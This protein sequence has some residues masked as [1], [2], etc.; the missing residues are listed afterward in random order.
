MKTFRT[1]GASR[2]A[3]GLLIGGCML[4][5]W[6]VLATLVDSPAWLL[7]AVVFLACVAGF[8]VGGT[9]ANGGKVPPLAV[10]AGAWSAALTGLVAASVFALAAR[11]IPNPYLVLRAMLGGAL[12]VLP[13]M[14]YG[15][16]AAGVAAVV[17][18]AA[19]SIKRVDESPELSLR[20]PVAWALRVVIALLVALGALLPLTPKP[21][22][23]IVSAKPQAVAPVAPKPPPPPPFTYKVPT[24]MA[25]AQASQWRIASSWVLRGLD[26]RVVALSKDGRWFA[27]AAADGR[28]VKIFDLHAPESFRQVYVPHAVDR[29]SFNPA[30]DRL[31]LTSGGPSAEL[32][33][34][35]VEAS[36]FTS[37]PKPKGGLMP[38][39]SVLWWKDKE[40]LIAARGERSILNLDDLEIDAAEDV[41]SW[42]E[43]SQEIRD[44]V[45]RDIDGG[46]R[47]T[48]RWAWKAKDYL[49]STELPARGGGNIL[50]VN[51]KTVV[52]MAHPDNDTCTLFG[53]LPT[54]SVNRI[55]SSGDGSKVLM[56]TGDVANICYFEIGEAPPLAWSVDMPCA[57]AD[58][59][60][61]SAV[62]KALKSG[63]LAALIYAPMTNPL[64][65]AVVG[66]Q[67]NVVKAQVRFQEWKER[68]ARVYISRSFAPV[69]TGDVVGDACSWSEERPELLSLRKPHAWWAILH[70]PEAGSDDVG[71]IPTLAARMKQAED[72]HK[73]EEAER[74]ARVAHDEEVAA[75]QRKL[76]ALKQAEAAPPAAMPVQVPQP[77]D[78]R[79]ER[80]RAFVKAHHQKS[81][82]GDVAGMVNDYAVRVDYFDKG[83]VDPNWIF[84]DEMRYHSSHTVIE[85]TV[86][87]PIRMTKL[88]NGYTASYVLKTRTREN[89][90]QRFAEMTFDVSLI[91]VEPFGSLQISRQRTTRKP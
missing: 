62:E 80:V 5:A 18:A 22:P 12:S 74:K 34:I 83:L 50:T 49:E 75:E 38:F 78:P 7:G 60:D 67:R 39:G 47:D 87:D 40:I 20:L 44:N 23:V 57:P 28:S 21:P 14:F 59:P 64:N 55:L 19:P 41:P 37:L 25:S 61:G 58:C 70:E 88:N 71:K 48:I 8:I 69:A 65:K 35:D 27:S 53:G 85:E 84:Q 43:T 56:L 63:S 89:A 77:A 86:V 54:S 26:S 76:L 16:F 51:R 11:S 73:G 4:F 6:P 81:V 3:V 10:R 36:R 42:K 45:V 91:L 82:N 46:F 79:F 29:L 24:E 2:E 15:M 68:K 72:F 52:G 31:F 33:I 90:S 32:G 9:S 1:L 66:P 13:G 17:F 30:T